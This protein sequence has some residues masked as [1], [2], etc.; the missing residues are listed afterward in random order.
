MSY[1]FLRIFNYRCTLLYPYSSVLIFKQVEEK[2]ENVSMKCIGVANW[3]IVKN[4]EKL[5]D[6]DV[7]R[8][9]RQLTRTVTYDVSTRRN[10]EFKHHNNVE[11][12]LGMYGVKK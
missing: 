3:G 5:I 7:K 6:P 4:K 12:Y 11:E 2:T 1:E 10:F 8:R 9:P